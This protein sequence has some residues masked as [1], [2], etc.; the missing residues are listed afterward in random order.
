MSETNEILLEYF[1]GRS[2]ELEKCERY[3]KEIMDKI[4]EDHVA[5]DSFLDAT[6]KKRSTYRDF[7]A[8]AKLEYE[9]SNFFK[10]KAINIYWN[11]GSVNA[12]SLAPL[13]LFR[14]RYK[15]GLENGKYTN[16]SA[17]ILMYEELV[18]MA[19][20]NER[21]LLAILLHEI[22][23]CFYW[24]PVEVAMTSVYLVTNLPF[25]IVK[26]FVS[27][28]IQHA[29]V[30][31]SDFGK[32]NLPMVYNLINIFTD[33]INEIMNWLV[34]TIAPIGALKNTI[35]NIRNGKIIPE[36]FS[37]IDIPGYG[38]EKGADSFATRY[39]YGAELIT[40]LKKIERPANTSAF[41]TM[42]KFGTFGDIIMDISTIAC[43]LVSMMMLDPHPSSS[44]RALSMIKKLKADLNESDFPPEMENDLRDEIARLEKAYNVLQ[45][46]DNKSN[47][48]LKRGWYNI[49]DKM[50]HGHT[51][52]REILD[53]YFD[54]FRF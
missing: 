19:D 48:A 14:P 13:V 3:L 39:G 23:H 30:R 36:G 40:A 17:S 47:V 10:V 52:I 26:Q 35:N 29:I 46:P 25:N 20:L 33:A 41:R 18:Y 12:A 45:D 8:N 24:C 50:T 1:A 32:K 9:L 49:V 16:M 54:A 28:T 51:D 38:A 4:K 43:D 5:T 11:N 7:P 37:P 21:E 53:F 42:H 27:L 2:K 31:M 6:K 15:A 34:V 44:Q 22:G